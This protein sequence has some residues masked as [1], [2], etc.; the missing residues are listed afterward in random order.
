MK[1]IFN[2]QEAKEFLTEK[3]RDILREMLS[4][5]SEAQVDRFNRMYK[6]VDKIKLDKIPWAIVQCSKTIEMNERNCGE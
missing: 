4:K 1:L 5:C 2:E 3:G 6:S